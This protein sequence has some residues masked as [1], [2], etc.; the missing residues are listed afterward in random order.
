MDQSPIFF[1]LFLI[2]SGAAVLATAA[3]LVRQA[4]LI[5]YIVLGALFG[6]WGLHLIGDPETVKEI[7]HI[8]IIFLL[9][10]L[11][12][13]LQPK[14][15]LGMVR[16]TTLVTLISS[17]IF[18]FI[19]AVL[20]FL[21]GFE[22]IEC[23]VIG[24]AVTFSS[25]IIGLKLLPTTVL[26][27]QRT[28]EIIVSILLLQDLLAIAMLLMLQGGSSEMNRVLHIVLLLL[29]LPL[30]VGGGWLVAQFMLIPLIRRFSKIKEYIFLMA[31]GWCLA[32]A[33]LAGVLGL[34]HEIGAFIAGIS[35]ATSPIAIYIAE[36]L[37]PL[38]D[39]FLIIFFFSLGAGF[40]LEMLP[41][42]ALPALLLAGLLLLIKSWVFRRLLYHAGEDNER[43]REVG[44]RLGQLSEF[45]LLV[46]VLAYDL[47]EIGAEASYLIQLS[48]LFTFLVSTYFIVLRFYTPMAISDRLRRD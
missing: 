17:L 48:T 16:K 3:L 19:G 8:G 28:G 14:E 30:M 46:A 12:L 37:K 33:E 45:S 43:S 21:F 44:F 26:H 15:L 47:G 1:T 7:A 10:L 41:A 42:V 5:S 36:S 18:A 29:A 32:M 24:G 9:F 39:F 11:G 38:R 34:S 31:I 40:N 22:P 6:P 20:A 23:L 2:F 35:L 13:D 27:H 4:L 25:T